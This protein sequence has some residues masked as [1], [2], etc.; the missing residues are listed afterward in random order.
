MARTKAEPEWRRYAWA[1]VLEAAATRP[2]FTVA[3]VWEI[4]VAAHGEYVNQGCSSS[5]AIGSLMRKAVCQGLCA[6][7][8]WVPPIHAAAHNKAQREW[9]SLIYG[10]DN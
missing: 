7:N 10:K 4:F 2:Y 5:S 9:E 6:F 3:H 8:G 1:S